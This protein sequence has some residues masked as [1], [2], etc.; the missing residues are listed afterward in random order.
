[1]I[2]SNEIGAAK[3]TQNPASK[4]INSVCTKKIIKIYPDQSLMYALHLMN[5]FHVSRLPVVSR[6]D[7]KDMVGIITANDITHRFGLHVSEESN[8]K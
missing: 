4:T 2:S 7:D 3:A 5:K 6:L 1:M 8:E